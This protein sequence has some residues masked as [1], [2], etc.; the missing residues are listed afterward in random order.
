MNEKPLIVSITANMQILNEIKEGY[1]N[2]PFIVSLEVAAPEASFISEKDGFWF[3]G[4]WLVIPNV[5]HIC[6]A[7]FYLAHDALGHFVSDKSYAALRTA[8][9]WPNMQKHLEQAYVPSCPECQHNKSTTNKPFRPLHPLPIPEQQGDS[10]A[11]DFIGL[12]PEDKGF[13]SII[14]FTDRLDS[15]IQIVPSTVNL[16]AEMLADLFF[17]KWYCENRLPLKIILDRDKLFMSKFWAH[18]HKLTRVKLKMSTAYHPETDRASEQFNKTV[19]QAIHFH[20]ERN[21]QGWV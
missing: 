21:Q 4:T 15:D 5:P 12:L 10:V 17:D 19:I 13:D 18:L 11:I 9:Y 14:T 8:Y 7:L 2:D 6:E 1:I 20:V 3:I 16:S